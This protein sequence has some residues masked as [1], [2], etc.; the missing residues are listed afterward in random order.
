MSNSHVKPWHRFH[1]CSVPRSI[2]MDSLLMMTERKN[3]VC[4]FHSSWKTKY[5]FDIDWHVSFVTLGLHINSFCRLSHSLSDSLLVSS[6]FCLSVSFCFSLSVSFCFSFCSSFS[7][8]FYLQ[9]H[10]DVLQVCLTIS[11]LWAS[12]RYLVPYMLPSKVELI[13]TSIDMNDIHHCEGLLTWYNNCG[14]DQECIEQNS[15]DLPEKEALWVS[16]L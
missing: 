7:L 3:R 9:V 11:V 12:P 6:S 10:V 2:E 15:L 16:L 5:S 14:C 4:K 1:T 13:L 8:S